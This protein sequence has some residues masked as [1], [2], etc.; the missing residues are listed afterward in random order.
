VGPVPKS[1]KRDKKTKLK[2]YKGMSEA[3]ATKR[4][5]T[6]WKW[7]SLYIRLRDCPDNSQGFGKCVTCGKVDHYKN[8]DAGH[9]VSRRWKPTKYRED[10]VSLQDVYCNRDLSGNLDEYAKVLGEEKVAELKEASRQP[11]K[12]MPLWEVERMIAEYR[13][14]AKDEAYRVGVEIR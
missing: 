14:K 11:A 10:N 13:Q 8:M 5:G 1:V 3:K 2:N 7:F 6:L 4:E 12:K 9:F